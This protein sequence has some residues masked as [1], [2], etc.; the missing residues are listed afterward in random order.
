MRQNRRGSSLYLLTISCGNALCRSSQA[1]TH[2]VQHWLR[3]ESYPDKTDH[4]QAK[5]RPFSQTHIRKFPM[6]RVGTL[7]RALRKSQTVESRHKKAQGGDD[8]EGNVCPIGSEQDEEFAH[9]I[10]KPWKPKGSHGKN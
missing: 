3:I 5:H 6:M 8:G 1:R 7:K 10:S 9:E 4:H 2:C